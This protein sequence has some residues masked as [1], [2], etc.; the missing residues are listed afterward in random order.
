MVAV[1]GTDAAGDERAGGP[2]PRRLP[3]FRSPPC[4]LRLC[5]YHASPHGEV[6]DF[7]G[8]GWLRASELP[9]LLGR[10]GPP[11]PCEKAASRFAVLLEA[12]ERLVHQLEQLLA[13]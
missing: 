10:V 6:G 3:L 1:I 12:G 2:L 11:L 8:F 5:G 7:V 9:G 4:A 13:R